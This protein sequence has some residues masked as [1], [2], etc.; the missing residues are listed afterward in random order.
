MSQPALRAAGLTKRYG[1][2]TAL[3][4]AGHRR[5]RRRARLDT[6]PVPVRTPRPVPLSDSAWTAP[7]AMLAA[8]ATLTIVGVAG[9]RRRDLQ[10]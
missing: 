3:D 4:D 2:L 5:Q 6:R 7:T 1:R 9:S 8:A 10:S